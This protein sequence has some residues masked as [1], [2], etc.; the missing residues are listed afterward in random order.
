[1]TTITPEPLTA[2]LDLMDKAWSQTNINQSNTPGTIGMYGTANAYYFYMKF[3]ANPSDNWHD[4]STTTKKFRILFQMGGQQ[5]DWTGLW[6]EISTTQS[7]GTK[8]ELDPISVTNSV[9]TQGAS[10]IDSQSRDNSSFKGYLEYTT[11]NDVTSTTVYM[12]R[13][14]E[15]SEQ[16]TT[17]EDVIRI[18]AG[19]SLKGT[20]YTREGTGISFTTE[21]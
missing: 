13:L 11:T 18:E 1:M 5:S 6:K 21:L 15:R 17:D 9:K 8:L 12:N 4:G 2:Q 14:I 3:T 19:R 20:Y 16:T 10:Q 7:G